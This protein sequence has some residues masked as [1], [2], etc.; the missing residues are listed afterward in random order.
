MRKIVLYITC[1]CLMFVYACK[2]ILEEDLGKYKIIIIA[3]TDELQTE[4]Q[5]HTFLWEKN[6]YVT[7][8]EF[9]IVS[10]SFQNAERIVSNE[11]LPESDN[12]IEVT[13]APGIY[14]WRVRGYNNSSETPYSTHSLVID[15]SLNL[16]NNKVVNIF[17]ADDEYLNSTLLSFSWQPLSAANSYEIV[18]RKGDSNG[19]PVFSQTG[20]TTTSVSNTTELAND[21]YS[22][23]V[24]AV[25][26]NSVT[27]WDYNQFTVDTINPA[28]PSSLLP[29][30]QTIE[31]DSSI[32]FS[33]TRADDS[34][35]PISD[36]IFIYSDQNLN[37]LV[38]AQA[39]SNRSYTDGTLERDTL[40]WRV[41]SS[42]AAGNISSYSTSQSVILQ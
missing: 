22:W 29:A 18:V 36:S 23:A 38:K 5:T 9:Q 33:W 31:T 16:T 4:I 12:S 24:R 20:I 25:N 11:D 41:R 19:D 7:G 14:E 28:T 34:G 1:F 17:P 40:Y 30:D 42:D 2:D 15:S 13:L 27:S 3:P 6:Q 26:D 32:T 21:D 39:A 35:A 37:Q 8:Y 10:K